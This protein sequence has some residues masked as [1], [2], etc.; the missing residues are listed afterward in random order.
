MMKI[1]LATLKQEKAMKEKSA[2]LQISNL[3][4][5]MAGTQRVLEDLKVVAMLLMV[6]LVLGRKSM[7]PSVGLFNGMSVGTNTNL[8]SISF[9]S[10]SF[11]SL[12]HPHTVHSVERQINWMK[13]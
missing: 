13:L 9:S 12:C 8:L 10:Y 11:S 7:S 3:K 2:S 5:K 1:D 4:Q 6:A